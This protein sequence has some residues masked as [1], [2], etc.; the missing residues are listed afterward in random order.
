[1]NDVADRPNGA[2]H[3]RV[4]C[5]RLPSPAS[6]PSRRRRT[7]GRG[8]RWSCGAWNRSRGA[9]GRPSSALMSKRVQ[10]IHP[11]LTMSRTSPGRHCLDRQLDLPVREVTAEALVAVAPV[12]SRQASHAGND[13]TVLG[14]GP[15]S[16]RSGVRAAGDSYSAFAR[17]SA[18]NL[19]L[20][21]GP[22]GP[23]L[24]R[25]PSGRVTAGRPYVMAGRPRLRPQ[26]VFPP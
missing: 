26:T 6:Y 24:T 17:S 21:P 18:E 19:P 14:A 8:C 4:S 11:R 5:T 20:R 9:R 13:D 2:T 10:M 12:R 25:C 3:V 1:M 7:T 15:R 22:A 16:T 23:W